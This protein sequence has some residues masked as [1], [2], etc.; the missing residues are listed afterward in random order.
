VESD[1]ESS[2]S[3][4]SSDS[5]SRDGQPNIFDRGVVYVYTGDEWPSKLF[6]QD[7]DWFR[8]IL[9][10]LGIRLITENAEQWRIRYKNDV[11][12]WTQMQDAFLTHKWIVLEHVMNFC[13]LYGK[14][15]SNLH[16]ADINANHYVTV[17]K[18]INAIEVL[19]T[20]PDSNAPS[21]NDPVMSQNKK[22]LM[23]LLDTW[24]VPTA[25]NEFVTISQNGEQHAIQQIE[26]WCKDKQI[27]NF[28]VKCAYSCSGE[29]FK[30]FELADRT[31]KTT[32]RN[33]HKVVVALK[34]PYIIVQRKAPEMTEYKCTVVGGELFCIEKWEY[35]E[36]TTGDNT[37]EDFQTTT[38]WSK[39]E[40][41]ETKQ[42]KDTKS[43]K[44]LVKLV[45]IDR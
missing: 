25:T 4:P 15:Y 43:C 24:G 23:D 1:S 19:R 8:K 17:D 33:Y 10:P 14:A 44:Q 9:R 29:S 34:Q 5:D 37:V 20:N 38:M 26:D 42:C 12:S 3:T 32:F 18:V 27:G 11:N 6:R 45:Y 31:W 13:L 30:C 39:V 35:K 21:Q 22:N 36:I 41:Y 7:E 28:V 40:G 16:I 2:A